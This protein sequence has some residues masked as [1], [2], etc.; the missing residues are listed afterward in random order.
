MAQREFVLFDQKRVGSSSIASNT[1]PG[2][3]CHAISIRSWDSVRKNLTF[4]SSRRDREQSRSLH[5]G[6]SPKSS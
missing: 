3:I 4:V 6:D 5:S 1:T 2:Q